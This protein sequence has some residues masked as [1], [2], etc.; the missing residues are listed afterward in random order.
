MA[1]PGI[2]RELEILAALREPTRLR[3]YRLVE[4]SPMPVSRDEAAAAIGISRSL[5]AFHLDRLVKLRLLSAKYRRLSGRTGPGAGRPSK[6]YQRSAHLVQL[7][8][9]HR[10]HELLARALSQAFGS[11][12]T[13]LV[14]IEP[15]REAGRS[16][17]KRARR[18]LRGPASPERILACVQ[19]MLDGLG[20]DP[21]R[22]SATE[23]RFRNCPFAPLSRLFSPLVCGVAMSLTTGVAEGVGDELGVT[24]EYRAAVCCPVVR[25]SDGPGTPHPLE[26]VPDRAQR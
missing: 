4:R 16:L 19:D 21:Y 26:P 15:A 3:L 6:L 2:E 5:A 9:P 8:L 12:L 14:D 17:G 22:P 11:S 10:D 25:L 1:K 13:D 20:F 7:S 18:R 23:I 24:R